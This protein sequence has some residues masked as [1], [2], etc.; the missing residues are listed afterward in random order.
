MIKG[1]FRIVFREQLFLLF[2]YVKVEV[3]KTLPS[4]PVGGKP[5]LTK[6]DF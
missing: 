1:C 2:Q 6:K 4:H 5:P 3:E